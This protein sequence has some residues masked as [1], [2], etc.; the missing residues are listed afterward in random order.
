MG[1]G[2]FPLPDRTW[3]RERAGKERWKEGGRDG[4]RGGGKR[5]RERQRERKR[6]RER[7]GLPTKSARLRE[8][9]EWID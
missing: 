2:P 8:K 5:E 1:L 7:D 4:A 3:E 9:M 6:K